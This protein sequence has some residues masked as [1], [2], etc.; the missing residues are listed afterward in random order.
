MKKS[1]SRV[2]DAVLEALAMLGIAL[3]AGVVIFWSVN[4]ELDGSYGMETAT[5]L[6]AGILG[7][8]LIRSFV[9]ESKV[10]Y[11]FAVLVIIEAILLNQAPLP[12][13]GLW[14]LLIPG[15]AIGLMA[16]AGV[17]R[18]VVTSKP[19]PLD[20]WVVNGEETPR[21]DTAKAKSL[22]AL[23]S[24]DAG[25]TGR[26]YVQRNHG[27]FEAVGNPAA[28]FIVH[29]T[30]NSEEEA[31]WRLL[32]NDNGEE[33]IE[34]RLLSGPAYAPKGVLTDLESTH[35]AL[36]GFFHYRGPDPR[37]PWTSGEDVRTYRFGQT[38]Q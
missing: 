3:L 16:G 10:T 23:T 13:S 34:I 32:G 35:E 37:L 24:W 4:S 6:I 15:N 26:F 29:C 36:L 18:V 5:V 33:V 25:D 17:Q 30:P 19:Q 14:L 20:V 21:T 31:E 9:H 28:G 22:A 11:V 27:V 12:W 7:G 8:C 1:S 2:K 38:T